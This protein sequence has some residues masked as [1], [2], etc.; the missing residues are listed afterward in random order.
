LGFG[1]LGSAVSTF[2][3]EQVKRRP[4]DPLVEDLTGMVIRGLSAAIVVF[5]AVVG[6]LAVFGSSSDPNPYV[7]LLTCLI[8][9][10]FSEDVWNWARRRLGDSLGEKGSPDAKPDAGAKVK[11]EVTD[12]TAKPDEPAK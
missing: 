8:G 4:D 10:V 9:A 7:L 5:L 6:G 2:V 12:Q 1:L 11:D 3:R